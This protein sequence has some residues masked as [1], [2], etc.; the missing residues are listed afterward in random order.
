MKPVHFKNTQIPLH[1]QI[2]DYLIEMLRKGEINPLN[3]MFSEEEM[4]LIFG[5]SRTTI[6]KSLEHLHRSGLLYS[7]RGSGTFWTEKAGSLK[8]IKLSGINRQIFNTEKTS[9]KVL[10]KTHETGTDEVNLFFKNPQDTIYTVFRR[11]RTIDGE[12]M[13]FTTNFIPCETG[14]L[15]KPDHLKKMTMLETLETIPGIS[16][17]VIEHEVEITRIDS[18]ISKYLKLSVLDPVL[19]VRTS[20]FDTNSR[21]VEIVWTHF[22]ESRYK[23]KVVFENK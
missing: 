21:P 20:V 2:A 14:D 4:T 1:Y 15:I 10:S 6:R 17:G 5:V 7:K 11:L 9:V 8:H 12:P 23:F 22:V 19:T 16:L 18:D 3:K 13:S